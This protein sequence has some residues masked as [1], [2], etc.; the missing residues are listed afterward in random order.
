MTIYSKPWTKITLYFIVKFAIYQYYWVAFLLTCILR[1]QEHFQKVSLSLWIKI[2]PI[3]SLPN[4]YNDKLYQKSLKYI[5]QI[6]LYF[7]LQF[8][9]YSKALFYETKYILIF[10]IVSSHGLYVVIITRSKSSGVNMSITAEVH[11]YSKN[12]IKSLSHLPAWFSLIFLG[13]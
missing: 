2:E 8:Y 5:L 3:N 12:L 6:I 7:M 1:I 10:Q 11:E 13:F 9:P 4:K